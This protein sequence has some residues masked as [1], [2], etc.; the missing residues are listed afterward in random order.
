M[1][2]IKIEDLPVDEELQ[3]D[4]LK[5]IFGGIIIVN[6]M[7]QKV[8]EAGLAGHNYED[9]S[10]HSYDDL[11]PYKYESTGRLFPPAG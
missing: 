3:A 5:G 1:T 10:L 7:E 6:S 4:E 9:L 11:S 2:R 8:R